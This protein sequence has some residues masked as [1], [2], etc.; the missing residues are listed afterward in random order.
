M[1]K[2]NL[3]TRVIII[4]I[5]TI[6]GL[7]LVIGPRRRPTV[8]DFKWSGIKANL[9]NNIHLGLDL[10]GGSHLVM[11]VKTEEFLRR[12]TE[13][14]YVAAQNAAKDAGFEVK[15]GRADTSPGNYRV[16]LQ[17]A[18]PAKVT[19][20]KEAVQKK[21]E[22]GDTSVWN[23]SASGDTLTWSM[24]AAAERLLADNATTQA[25]NIIESRI[26]ALGIAEPTLQTHGAQSSHQLLLQMPG[27]Q[28]PERVKDI[29]KGE[30]RLEL[31]HVVSPPSP[32]PATEYATEQEA[33][34]SLN[35]GGQI[36]P[37]RRVLPYA[38]RGE[39]SQD[40]NQPRQ[41]RWVVVETPAIIDGSELRNAT[42]IPAQGGRADDYEINFSLKKSGADKFGAWTGSHINEYMGV[43][44][45]DEVKSVAFIKSQIFDSGQITGR[46]TKNSAEDL[47]LTLRSGA[48]PAPIEYLEERTVGP[49]LGQDSIRAGVRAS[50]VGLALVVVFML[51]Y[52]RG[53]GVNAVVA[54]LL[55]MILMLAGL[56]VFGATLT[57]PG[58]AGIILTIG[59][60]VDSNVLIFERIREELRS[61]KTIPSSVDLGFNRAFITI[62]DTHVTTIISSLFLFVFGTGPIRG[63]A[64][65][66]VIGL[67]VNLFSA[68]YV[69]RTIFIWLLSRK[70]V[71]SLSI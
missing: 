52:Y 11:R 53:S 50:L 31:V 65:T 14:N 66:L 9:K 16:V 60:A 6:T 12:L 44:L 37:N 56:I 41:T 2:K 45:N 4:A 39:K 43:V 33:I 49:S 15:G 48:L 40:P 71:E 20:A 29:L 1:K 69:S 23:Y 21:V 54:L 61:G 30:S 32:S 38:E 25:L 46:F 27:V 8:Q 51:F 17:I 28:D 67:L 62:I 64:V 59:M 35:S 42:A 58:I 36:P 10:Q 22:L 68:V 18:D 5:V 34:A 7:Y 19:E 57:L 3:L 55:N 13:E 24:T 47:A 70:K 26:N 63:F